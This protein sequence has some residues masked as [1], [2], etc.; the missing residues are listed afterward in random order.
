MF[1][2]EE[3]DKIKDQMLPLKPD[4]FF[5]PLFY[6][7]SPEPNLQALAQAICEYARMTLESDQLDCI[8]L[9]STD[10]VYL[11]TYFI[12]RSD[13]DAQK[14]EKKAVIFTE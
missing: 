4:W 7:N 6:I 8:F 11:L 3:Q 9:T 2:L 13:I 14:G 10:L 12:I 1:D 5:R